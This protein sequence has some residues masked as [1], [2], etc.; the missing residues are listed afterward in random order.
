MGIVRRIVWLGIFVMALV[1]G[2]EFAGSN[3]SLGRVECE[4]CGNEM[5]M[6]DFRTAVKSNIKV[7]IF[8]HQTACTQTHHRKE[9]I[10]FIP[11]RGRAPIDK[12]SRNLIAT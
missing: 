1:G 10:R 2:W 5:K 12:A 9:I 7:T 4:G 6:A 8:I 3:G 11:S